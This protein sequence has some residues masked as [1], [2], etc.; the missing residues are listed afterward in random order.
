MAHKAVLVLLVGILV[1][2]EASED[3]VRFD[4]G[5]A[6]R[7]VGGPKSPLLGEGPAVPQK[8]CVDRRAELE[9]KVKQSEQSLESLGLQVVKMQKE[10]AQLRADT[11]N[12]NAMAAGRK[13]AQKD[14]PERFHKLEFKVKQKSLA[15]SPAVELTAKATKKT[16]ELNRRIQ[17]Q[18]ALLKQAQEQ[19]PKLEVE[20][21]NLKGENKLATDRSRQ[22]NAL[23]Q[24]KTAKYEGNFESELRRLAIEKTQ[25][26]RM[27]EVN[28]KL[29][30][31][32]L[33][34]RKALLT[35]EIAKSKNELMM[36]KPKVEFEEGR[37][38]TAEEQLASQR[39]TAEKKEDAAR[40][41][42]REAEDRIGKEVT[43][44]AQFERKAAEERATKKE[45]EAEKKRAALQEV[46][47]EAT[48]EEKHAAKNAAIRK[49]QAFQTLKARNEELQE[50]IQLVQKDSEIKL[51]AIRYKSIQDKAQAQK[52]GLKALAAYRKQ[53]TDAANQKV[54]D[55]V[56]AASAQLAKASD[57]SKEK[58]KD[59]K[60]QLNQLRDAS[61]AAA[62]S[63]DRA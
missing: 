4:E 27:L 25:L 8:P 59:L 43:E 13:K 32:G 6:G 22:L 18:S 30:T 37:V 10:T 24:K 5:V 19:K 23:L 47:K 29:Q 53:K 62:G 51:A 12:G 42:L 49:Q 55:V 58:T 3:S 21:K 41:Q 16:N 63:D 1:A 50:E 14:F 9:T 7:T 26:T 2:F 61:E 52:D 20:V 17:E 33:G 44:K 54:K 57:G 39:A 45:I 56:E 35:S 40:A 48:V 38:K 34:A 36:L 28:K 46:K 15:R 31:S 60:N 11:E